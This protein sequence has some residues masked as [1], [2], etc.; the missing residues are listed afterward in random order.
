MAAPYQAHDIDE[1]LKVNDTDDGNM[2]KGLEDQ[3][4]K[5]MNSSHIEEPQS[6]AEI[7]N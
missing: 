1:E 4:L 7:G 5:L 3:W 6:P 2:L